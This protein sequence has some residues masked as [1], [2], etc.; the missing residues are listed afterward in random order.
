MYIDP[1]QLGTAANKGAEHV[2]K[3]R[4]AINT[5]NKEPAAVATSASSAPA[6]K[7]SNK[8]NT[9]TLEENVEFQTSAHELYE[10]LLD[11]QRVCAWTRG[12]AKISK[13][14]NSPFEL[15]NGNVRGEILELVKFFLRSISKTLLT[16]RVN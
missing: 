1:S 12:P 2:T 10:T 8:V 3:E 9:T 4:T 7:S 14:K 11:T 13:E 15:F 5:G 16:I 6:P